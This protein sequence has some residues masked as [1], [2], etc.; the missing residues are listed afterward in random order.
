MASRKIAAGTK[1][2]PNA[3]EEARES[4]DEGYFLETPTG[5]EG[6]SQR[7]GD[8]FSSPFYLFFAMT[9]AMLQGGEVCSTA[10]SLP[11]HVTGP[12]LQHGA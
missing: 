2:D 8:T 12:R 11:S 10:A 6:K 1:K 5:G 7:G 4:A 3:G 9:G